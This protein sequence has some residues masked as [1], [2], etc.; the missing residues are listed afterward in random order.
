MSNMFPKLGEEIVQATR[1]AVAAHL[2]SLTA[3]ITPRQMVEVGG[4]DPDSFT[5]ERLSSGR[6]SSRLPW[7]V[8]LKAGYADGGA[9]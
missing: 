2:Q 4:A 8:E 7:P 6:L 3:S 5:D 9:E 1:L